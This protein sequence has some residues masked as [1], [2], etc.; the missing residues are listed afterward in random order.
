LSYAQPA[1]PGSIGEGLL[2]CKIGLVDVGVGNIRSIYKCLLALDTT[3]VLISRPSDI[4]G[5]DKLILPGVGHFDNALARL[6]ALELEEPLNEAVLMRK[7]PV[8]GVCLGM[9]LMAAES[10]EGSAKGL[11]WIGARVVRFRVDNPVRN[12]VPHIGWNSIEITRPSLLLKNVDAESEY[13]F[14]HSYHLDTEAAHYSPASTTY[15]YSFPSVL[16]HGNIFGTQ[17]HPE[18]SREA[19]IVIIQN[20][21]SL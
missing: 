20:F 15:D 4:A 1:K 2:A 11:G 16:E 7:T 17:F 10:E 6:K 13:Y 19:G 3:P 18:K 9:Q 5:A 14:V 8:L 12:K 21:L